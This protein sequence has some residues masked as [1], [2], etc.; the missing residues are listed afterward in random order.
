MSKSIHKV[1]EAGIQTLSHSG[2]AE[3]ALEARLL[4]EAVLE[5]DR[6]YLV[7][8]KDEVISEN[9]L[10][11]YF[12]WIEERVTGRPIQYILKQQEFMGL[13]FRVTPFTLVPRR[14]T[15]EL[16]ELALNFLSEDQVSTIMDIGTGTGCIPIS[17]T[18]LNKKVIAIGVDLSQEA[19]DVALDNSLMHKVDSR[20]MWVHS[21]IFDG[22]DSVWL[23]KIDM[24]LSNPP[25]IR[26]ED[27]DHLMLEVK[28]FEPR[29]ALDGG[30]DGL[31]FYRRICKDAKSFLKEGGALLLEIGY[32][33]GKEV[34]E[35]LSQYGFKQVQCK[36]D[37]S[38]MDRMI[39]AVK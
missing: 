13:K 31:D 20:I 1:L 4:L 25:Y 3:A 19:L 5:C 7:I 28:G 34:C 37:L 8:H 2:K 10:E 39:C 32:D 33:Q 35:L 38:G 27:I 21:D 12:K 26:T 24:I 15:E 17:L 22:I 18:V 6:T 9:N 16:V 11:Q 30:P 29:M 23:G 36:K 14:E